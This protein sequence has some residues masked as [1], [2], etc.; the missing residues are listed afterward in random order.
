MIRS[1]SKLYYNSRLTGSG[2]NAKMIKRPYSLP[3]GW[4]YKP[5]DVFSEREWFTVL[6]KETGK[7]LLLDKNI[8]RLH[9][10][11]NKTQQKVASCNMRLCLTDSIC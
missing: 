3:E 6:D 4:K 1:D 2:S 9:L 7:V 5:L 8:I 11:L 10:D